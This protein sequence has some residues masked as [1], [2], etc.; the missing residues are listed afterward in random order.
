[1]ISVNFTRH[2]RHAYIKIAKIYQILSKLNFFCRTLTSFSEYTNDLLFLWKTTE[3][4]YYSYFS[5]ARHNY[6][7][8]DMNPKSQ[9]CFLC[10]GLVWFGFR[11]YP[12][13]VRYCKC[14]LNSVFTVCLK[15]WASIKSVCRLY[16][17]IRIRIIV[18]KSNDK[19]NITNK[20][21]QIIPLMGMFTKEIC[22]YHTLLEVNV[23]YHTK[24][25]HTKHSPLRSDWNFTLVCERNH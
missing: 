2:F 6:C 5:Y 13:L 22:K 16:N 20:I 11:R 25:G 7:F 3:L 18:K 8:E 1:M 17:T 14:L 12:S 23:Y 9:Y 24:C 4:G 19:N 15:L 21:Q 10:F